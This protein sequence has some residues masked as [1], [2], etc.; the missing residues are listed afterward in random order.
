MAAP[1]P[2][3]VA[4]LARVPEVNRDLLDRV[5]RLAAEACPDAELVL[6]YGMPTFRSG[7]HRLH[8]GA[9]QHGVSLYGWRAGGDAGFTARHPRLRSGRGTIRIRPED[10]ATIGDD[11]FRE[12]A[13]AVLPADD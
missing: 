3:V 2:D 8:V 9:W 7:R 13:R 6:A 12:L 4:Y 10:A 11:E 5:L 1:S